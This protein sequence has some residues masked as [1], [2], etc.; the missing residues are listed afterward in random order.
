MSL[1]KCPQCGWTYD[2]ATE[3]PAKGDWGSAWE[4]V[5]THS[6]L[7]RAICPGSQQH[8]RNAETDRRPLW[9]EEEAD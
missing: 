8:P 1:Y 2:P 9:S 5:P 7:T 4:L 3:S 6:S